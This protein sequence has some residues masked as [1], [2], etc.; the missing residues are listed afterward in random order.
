MLIKFLYCATWKFARF[1]NP[2]EAK[3]S[4]TTLL[5]ALRLFSL[6]GLISPMETAIYIIILIQ[7]F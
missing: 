1:L 5:F 7:L 6:R 3:V 4:R 2:V